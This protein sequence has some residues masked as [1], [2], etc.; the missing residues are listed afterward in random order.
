[1]LE[2]LQK[3]RICVYSTFGSERV[4]VGNNQTFLTYVFTIINNQLQR[5]YSVT[6][7]ES[8]PLRETVR[9]DTR[10]SVYFERFFICFE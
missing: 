6:K 4:L 1:M 2:G 9:C 7:K 10:F 8:H 3:F 5:L